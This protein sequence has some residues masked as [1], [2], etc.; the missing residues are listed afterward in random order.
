MARTIKAEEHAGKRNDI[1]DATQRLV[2]TKG[3]ERM[4][5]QDILDDL[6]ISKGAFYHYFSSKP[7]VLEALSARMLDEME[8]PLSHIVHTADLPAIE[9]LRRFFTT[10]TEWK[11]THQ[12]L[13]AALLHVWFAD[14]NAIVR[15]KVDAETVKRLAP[16][17]TAI[18]EQGIQE[19]VF[20]TSYP[21]QAGEVILSLVQGLQS[22]IARVLHLSQPQLDD[23]TRIQNTVTAYAAYMDALERVLG[24]P[25]NSLQRIDASTVESRVV[26][27]NGSK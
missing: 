13:V 24:A 10:F 6:Q 1:L 9:K 23:Q 15:Q 26:A 17:L 19:K 18:I 25:S 8:Q 14:D 27:L 3:Y 12:T 20:T 7:A 11:A 21:Q 5:I 16:L 4:T 22:A 2:Y